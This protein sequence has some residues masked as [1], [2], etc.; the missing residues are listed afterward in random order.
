MMPGRDAFQ[1]AILR[2]VPRIDRGECM[3][4]GVVLFCP[5]R[6]Y[7]EAMIQLDHDRLRALAPGLQP[8]AVQP[9]LDAILAVVRGDA[10]GGALARL[11]P[12]ERF[13]WVVANSST[14][15]QPSEVHT[16]LTDDPASTLGHLFQSL[17]PV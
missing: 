15:I 10:R 8:G 7:L 9:H 13:G 6:K 4:V 11:S 12:S 1:Y 14:V 3:N 5:Q 2:V 16:G 17:V